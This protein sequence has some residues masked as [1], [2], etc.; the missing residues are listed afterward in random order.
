MYSG[1][2]FSL[3]TNTNQQDKIQN[4]LINKKKT[5]IK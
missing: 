5:K 2:N 4:S 3:V 1:E